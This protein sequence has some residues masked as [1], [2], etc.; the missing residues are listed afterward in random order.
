MNKSSDVEAHH[1][2]HYQS[3]SSFTAEPDE[4][5]QAREEMTNIIQTQEEINDRK[6][7]LLKRLERYKQEKHLIEETISIKISNEQQREILKQL[8]KIHE[9]QIKNIELESINLM[10]EFL[11]HQ[12]DMVVKRDHKRQKLV[13]EIV[14]LQKKIISGSILYLH[15]LTRRARFQVF[16]KIAL[17]KNISKFTG[18]YLRLSPFFQDALLLNESVFSYNLFLNRDYKVVC[19]LNWFLIDG[20]H[21]TYLCPFFLQYTLP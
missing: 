2:S 14:T 11:S 16:Y 9:Y 21:L 8:C 13:K 20:F 1:S 5:K 15:I 12:K 4:I 18:K 7:E 6:E 10:K 17:L 3:A 19:R